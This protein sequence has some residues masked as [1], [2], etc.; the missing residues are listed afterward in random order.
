MIFSCEEKMKLEEIHFPYN[1]NKTGEPYLTVSDNELF[2]S[3]IEEKIDSNF[4]YMSKLVDNKWNDKE[5]IVKGKI[6]LLIGL[7]FHLYLSIKLMV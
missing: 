3:W 4:L 7:I 6:G 1:S 5:L 2:I